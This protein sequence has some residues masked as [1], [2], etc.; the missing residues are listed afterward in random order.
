MNIVKMAVLKFSEFFI[1]TIMLAVIFMK[2]GKLY[3]PDKP[4]GFLGILAGSIFVTGMF[5]LVFGYLL[6]SI[7]LLSIV[8]Q[9][10]RW[11]PVWIAA[12][13]AMVFGIH[14][15]VVIQIFQFKLSTDLWI[16]WALMLL[17]NLALPFLYSRLAPHKPK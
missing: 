5:F 8:G 15:L 16:V 1:M 14:S 4:D 13:G 2:D 3:W 9:F 12:T 17:T 11:R 6:S 10:S 7:V